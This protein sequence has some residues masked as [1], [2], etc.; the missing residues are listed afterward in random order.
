MPGTTRSRSERGSKP[1]LWRPVSVHDVPIIRDST[2]PLVLGSVDPHGREHPSALSPCVWHLVLSYETVRGVPMT[3]LEAVSSRYPLT[4]VYH[5]VVGDG[6][7]ECYSSALSQSAELTYSP[8]RLVYHCVWYTRRRETGPVL[9]LS[10]THDPHGSTKDTL[11]LGVR[12]GLCPHVEFWSVG[13]RTTPSRI[14]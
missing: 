10:L 5:T 14:M 7:G 11:G 13:S 1:C 2:D 6:G 9:V 12:T 4:V 3:A 8:P